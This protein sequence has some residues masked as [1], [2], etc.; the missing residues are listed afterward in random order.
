MFKECG[1]L[2]ADIFCLAKT[3]NRYSFCFQHN[4]SGLTRGIFLRI[5]IYIR[6]L[7]HLLNKQKVNNTLQNKQK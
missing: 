2:L 7:V 5:Y 1:S 3:V 4:N 6:G